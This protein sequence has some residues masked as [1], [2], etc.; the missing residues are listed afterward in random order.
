MDDKPIVVEVVQLEH[1]RF[2]VDFPGIDAPPVLTDEM[3]PL[4]DGGAPNPVRLLAAGVANCLAASLLYALQRYR[5]DPYPV[6]A[7]V[8]VDLN[9]DTAGRLRVAGMA[10][11]LR[12]GAR[13][14]ALHHATRALAQ[15]EAFCTVTESVRRGIPVTVDV[16]DACDDPLNA[17]AAS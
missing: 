13:W 10:V 3:P 2:R 1:F 5:N 15:F 6:T 11:R 14:P 4:G 12:V 8:D 16:R 9:R 17:E 7:R